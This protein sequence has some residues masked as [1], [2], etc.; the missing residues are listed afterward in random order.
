[1]AGLDIG[2]SKICMK[3]SGSDC[4]C[5]FFCL[6]WNLE[7]MLSVVPQSLSFVS[8]LYVYFKAI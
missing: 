3:G 7:G 1:M 4:C 2:Q 6:L 8:I 5:T